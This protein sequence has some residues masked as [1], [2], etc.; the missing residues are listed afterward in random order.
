MQKTGGKETKCGRK[1]KNQGLQ[2]AKRK[3]KKQEMR[4]MR[5][6]ELFSKFSSKHPQG[7]ISI[8]KCGIIS[9]FA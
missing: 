9:S 2:K 7:K 3:K 4:E 5:E 1:T 6:R 8:I